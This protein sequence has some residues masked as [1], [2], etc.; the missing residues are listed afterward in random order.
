MINDDFSGQL[1]DTALNMEN[2]ELSTEKVL[3]KLCS[4]CLTYSKCMRV[5]NTENF[6]ELTLG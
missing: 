5:F 6:L 4:K 3:A 1:R 2:I